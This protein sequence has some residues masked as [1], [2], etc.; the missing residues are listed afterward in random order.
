M[1]Y[2]VLL[3]PTTLLFRMTRAIRDALSDLKSGWPLDPRHSVTMEQFEHAAGIGRWQ[4]VDP[5]PDLS[6]RR[7][8]AASR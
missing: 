4:V 5:A 3:F 6:S 8:A 7:P 2:Q 1:G